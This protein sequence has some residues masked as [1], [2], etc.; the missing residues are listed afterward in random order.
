MSSRL[1]E[2]E[3]SPPILCFKP[4]YNCSNTAINRI[5]CMHLLNSYMYKFL[6]YIYRYVAKSFNL[7]KRFEK[8]FISDTVLLHRS[9]IQTT[10]KY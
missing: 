8:L 6:I 4:N 1:D 9:L 7:Y 5:E 2:L 10:A 3:S